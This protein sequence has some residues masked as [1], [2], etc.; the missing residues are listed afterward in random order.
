MYVACIRGLHE[1]TSLGNICC[2][3]IYGS[4]PIH[5]ALTCARLK[6]HQG[7]L[8]SKQVVDATLRLYMAFHW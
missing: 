1:I 2:A 5:T 3:L 6:I 7:C 8:W 4:L